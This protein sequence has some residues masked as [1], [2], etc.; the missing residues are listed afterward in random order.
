MLAGDTDTNCAI[1][2]GLVGSYC[3]IANIP[4]DKVRKVLESDHKKSYTKQRPDFVKP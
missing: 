1:V 2:G 3:G 4:K